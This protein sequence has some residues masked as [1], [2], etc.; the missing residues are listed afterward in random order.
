[1]IRSWSRYC[2][3]DST[4][5]PTENLFQAPGFRILVNVVRNALKLQLVKTTKGLLLSQ[6]YRIGIPLRTTFPKLQDKVAW[7]QGG[8]TYCKFK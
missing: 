6:Q 3:I 5:T 4:I 2:N 8:R 1:M 7:S